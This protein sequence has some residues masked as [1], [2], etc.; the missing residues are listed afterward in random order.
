MSN[1]FV[2]TPLFL[3]TSL[4]VAMETIHFCIAQIKTF[5]ETFFRIQGVQLNNLLPIKNCPG[6]GTR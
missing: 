5:W 4:L 3:K 6:G 2:R 1:Y